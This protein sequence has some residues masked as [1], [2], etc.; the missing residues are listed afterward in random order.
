[1]KTRI[2]V[3]MIAVALSLTMGAASRVFAHQG[4]HGD[5]DAVYDSRSD[6][7]E[8]DGYYDSDRSESD[9]EPCDGPDR[10]DPRYSY[11]RDP[12]DSYPRSR[13]GD[14]RYY[15]SG[16]YGGGGSF[17]WKRDWPLLLGTM[18]NAQVGR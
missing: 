13:G 6:G 15:E 10:R 5:D 7:P 12:R 3:T 2:A 14:D 16:G 11:P 9:R 1:M 8:D 18:I 17:D 4:E